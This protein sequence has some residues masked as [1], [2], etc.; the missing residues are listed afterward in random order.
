MTPGAYG[1]RLALAFAEI[2]RKT[3]VALGGLPMRLNKENALLFKMEK[4]AREIPEHKQPEPPSQPSL[5]DILQ[6]LENMKG[7][8][9]TTLKK[10]AEEL[11][12]VFPRE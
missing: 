5:D 8:G 9:P 3:G 12:D 1:K 2:E 11:G 6:V 10:V 4:L 7:F